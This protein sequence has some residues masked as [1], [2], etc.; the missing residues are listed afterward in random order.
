MLV[1]VSRNASPS[2]FPEIHPEIDSIG[3]I[4]TLKG[5]LGSL[6]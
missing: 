6:S 4:N 1:D 5:G 3:P 2:G